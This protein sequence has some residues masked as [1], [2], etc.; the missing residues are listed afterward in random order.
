MI[1][2]KFAPSGLNLVLCLKQALTWNCVFRE[3]IQEDEAQSW[4]GDAV[5]ANGSILHSMQDYL[6]TKVCQAIQ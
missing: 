3:T 4:S 5:A 6:G 1:D 2:V